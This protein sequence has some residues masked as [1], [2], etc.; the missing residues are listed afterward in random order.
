MFLKTKEGEYLFKGDS[1][2]SKGKD[3]DFAKIYSDDNIDQ[4]NSWL[5]NGIFPWNIYKDKIDVVIDRYHDGILGYFTPDESKY[6]GRHNLKKGTKI[7][8]LGKPTYLWIIKL[9]PQSDWV[10]EKQ[11]ENSINPSNMGYFENYTE[12]HRDEILKDV[13]KDSE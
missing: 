1:F 9:Y 3:P 8:E 5:R 13:L 12:Y 11:D 2:W 7:D 10:I 4:V 6:D